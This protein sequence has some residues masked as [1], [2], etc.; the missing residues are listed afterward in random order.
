VTLSADQ[1]TRIRESVLGGSNV[2]RIDNVNFAVRVG[3]V[4]PASVRFVA[5]PEALIAIHPEWRHHEYFVVRDEIII[6]DRD[7]RIVAMVPLGS[8]SAESSGA[9]TS[10]S[11]STISHDGGGSLSLSQEEIRQ[12]QIALNA[13]GFNIGTPDGVLGPR[14]TQ[15]LIQFQRREGFQPTGQIDSRTVTALGI[16]SKGGQPMGGQ[17]GMHQQPGMHGAAQPG[18]QGQ[19]P[20]AMPGAGQPG[21]STAGQGAGQPSSQGQQSTTGQGGATQ[22][23]ANPG[24]A[25]RP[26]AGAPQNGSGAPMTGG[27]TK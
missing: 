12:L 26:A 11:A 20:S 7:R 19:Q 4:V 15:A 6:V 10:S 27:Q 2:P 9:S 22:P 21:Q 5:V 1:R 23:S 14:T 8:S 18:S 25:N 13:K 24:A 3:T 16:S 17:S